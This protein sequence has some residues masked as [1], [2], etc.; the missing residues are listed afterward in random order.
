MQQLELPGAPPIVYGEYTV[1]GATRTYCFYVNYDGQPVDATAWKHGPFEPV[2]YDNPMNKGGKEIEFVKPGEIV[3]EEW[4]IYARSS[5]DD[6]APIAA[7]W[8]AIDALQ[9]TNIGFTSDIKLF[10]MKRRNLVLLM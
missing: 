5:S 7:L 10:L 1:P 4:R 8:S 6:K 9:A 2:L 3:D